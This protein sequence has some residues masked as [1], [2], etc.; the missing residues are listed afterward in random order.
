MV[1]VCSG[2][3]HSKYVLLA[4]QIELKVTKFSLNSQSSAVETVAPHFTDEEINSEKVE[5]G[6]KATQL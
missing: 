3:I 6:P 5:N 1:T 2:R 4:Y